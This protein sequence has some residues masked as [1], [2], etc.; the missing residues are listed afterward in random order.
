MPVQLS[1][2]E[3]VNHQGPRK[4]PIGF[5]RAPKRFSGMQTPRKGLRVTI[6]ITTDQQKYMVAEMLCEFPR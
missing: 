3:L 5:R 1:I 2:L 6:A 4:A